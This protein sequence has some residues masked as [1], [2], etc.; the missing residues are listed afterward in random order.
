MI[1]ESKDNPQA[2]V[3]QLRGVAK[4]I[5]C[6]IIKDLLRERWETMGDAWFPYVVDPDVLYLAAQRYHCTC[7]VEGQTMTLLLM[8]LENEVFKD[9]Y[10]LED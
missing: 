2:Q 5:L 10:E 1:D 7:L 8:D 3:H 6:N 9:L 4:N